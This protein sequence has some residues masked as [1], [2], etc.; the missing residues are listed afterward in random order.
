MFGLPGNP[1]SSLV[2]FHLAVV[3]CLRKMEGWQ[4]RGRW[5]GGCARMY[6][7]WGWCLAG[8]G[9]V[10]V[11]VPCWDIWRAGRCG[12]G[13]VGRG[14]GR[15]CGC[16]RR[17]VALPCQSVNQSSTHSFSPTWTAGATT[18]PG[19]LPHR[20]GHQNGPGAP[21]IPPRCR[22]LGAP[23]CGSGARAGTK[24]QRDARQSTCSCIPSIS[25]CLRRPPHNQPCRRRARGRLPRRACGG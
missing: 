24:V 13:R 9:A 22:P 14:W 11:V 12:S 25:L 19:A 20:N 16:A 6:V 5:E 10:L 17:T 1:V 3:P 8:G 21:R 4:V 18:A 15:A 2:T 7:E 23:R